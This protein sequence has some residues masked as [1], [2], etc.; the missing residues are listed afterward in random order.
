MQVARFW[1]VLYILLYGSAFA[2][3][4]STN[5]RRISKAQFQCFLMR[6]S[7]NGQNGKELVLI[8]RRELIG[9]G[10]GASA[11]FLMGSSSA[12]AAGLPPEE[13]PRLCDDV[14][15]K[16]LENVWWGYIAPSIFTFYF[17]Y[18]FLDCLSFDDS[19]FVRQVKG[20]VN[21]QESWKK[22]NKFLRQSHSPT[23]QFQNLWKYVY[24][25]RLILCD[26]S[27]FVNLIS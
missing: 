7:E 9:L 16:E 10:L 14:C 22:K 3:G 6:A 8:K 11:G 26:S 27:L 20:E 19:F 18:L 15:V 2:K 17:I 13:K 4:F 12:Q 1:Q 23:V 24:S 21:V 5:H 25:V